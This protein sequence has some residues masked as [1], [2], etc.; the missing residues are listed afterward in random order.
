MQ[1]ILLLTCEVEHLLEFAACHKSIRV[2]EWIASHF[3]CKLF[4]GSHGPNGIVSGNWNLGCK[5]PPIST[6]NKPKYL[7][8][9]L[10]FC[11]T[12]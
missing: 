12:P 5:N 4:H 8:F 9:A 7:C 2:Q 10:T 1:H 6:S 11:G 3:L